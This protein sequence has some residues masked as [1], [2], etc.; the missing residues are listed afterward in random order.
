MNL[1]TAFTEGNQM[2]TAHE[3]A[4]GVRIANAI[5]SSG[6][7]ITVHMIHSILL[8]V[9]IWLVFL[10]T[11]LF[12]LHVRS[13]SAVLLQGSLVP[14]DLNTNPVRLQKYKFFNALL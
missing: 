13:V 14:S 7:R 10:C 4:H 5:H 12:L 3:N 8:S 2:C 9:C 1:K 11:Y 6:P